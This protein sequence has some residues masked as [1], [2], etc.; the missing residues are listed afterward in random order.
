MSNVDDAR[1]LFKQF[2]HDG[3]GVLSQEEMRK[4]GSRFTS[5]EIEAL[6]AVG[7][8][9]GD[10]ELDINEFINVICPGATTVI[11][12]LRNI[13]FE[14]ILKTLLKQIFVCSSGFKSQE[15]M[16]NTFKQIDVDGDGKITKEEMTK[17]GELNDQE[18]NAIFELGDVDRDGTIDL[19]EFVGVMS[20]CA[21]V[22]YTVSLPKSL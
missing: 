18:V 10:G 9:N 15:D 17:F 8:I 20:S 2:D 6:F 7:D 1:F 21:P 16:E 14:L 5:K 22:P 11:S 3:D 12:R 4:S 19:E 13:S